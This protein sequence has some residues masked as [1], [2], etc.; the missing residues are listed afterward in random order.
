MDRAA[1]R[2]DVRRALDRDQDPATAVWVLV[3]LTLDPA[4]DDRAL[5]DLL[6]HQDRA[7]IALALSGAWRYA[8]IPCP[9]VVVYPAGA[10]PERMVLL[11]RLTFTRPPAGGG[12]TADELDN[13]AAAARHAVEMRGRSATATAEPPCRRRRPAQRAR[14]RGRRA[15][16]ADRRTGL[17][18]ARHGAP[19]PRRDHGQPVRRPADPLPGGPRAV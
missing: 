12:L 14:G 17:V 19:G 13:L 5:D 3:T 8:K 6:N 16:P 2:L 18:A 11:T 1:H 10:G 15:Q 4:R 9:R 7:A